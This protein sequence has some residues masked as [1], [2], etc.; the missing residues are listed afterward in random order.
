MPRNMSFAITTEQFRSRTKTV[1]RRNGWW[2]LRP[3]QIVCGCVKCMGLKPGEK[4]DRLGLIRILSSAASPEEGEPLRRMVE[5]IDYGFTETTKEGFPEG[6]PKHW[7][8]VFAEMFIANMGG[9]LDTP[10]NR[11]EFEYVESEAEDA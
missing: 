4:I 1:T 9:D 2:N 10:R 11:I 3:G 7:P 6:H 5:N 8:S